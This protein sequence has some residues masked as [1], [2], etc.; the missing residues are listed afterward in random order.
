MMP[1]GEMRM[2]ELGTATAGAG[3]F[4]EN[5]DGLKYKPSR[6]PP[7]ASELTCKKA[8]RLIE[9]V[10]MVISGVAQVVNLRVSRACSKLTTCATEAIR[11]SKTVWPFRDFR[12]QLCESPREYAG[13]FRTDK[14][15]IPCCCRSAR[16]SG[17]D[18]F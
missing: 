12:P 3:W 18:A 2:N 17:A 10:V 8:R 6:I 11:L 15:W 1:S 16:R 13:T 4:C 9:G 14:C 7:P 5:T